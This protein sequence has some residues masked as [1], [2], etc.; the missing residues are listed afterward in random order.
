MLADL[1][2]N[3]RKRKK[4]K[5]SFSQNRDSHIFCF[6]W[7]LDFRSPSRMRLPCLV[8]LIYVLCQW[9]LLAIRAIT[10]SVIF[11]LI[12]IRQNFLGQKYIS[13]S[14]DFQGADLHK[15][16]STKG[17][18]LCHTFKYFVTCHKNIMLWALTF[19]IFLS[20]WEICKKSKFTTVYIFFKLFIENLLF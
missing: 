11:I 3:T 18:N 9:L 6:C 10:Y 5:Y 15:I 2:G 17:L 13:N 1:H 12:L 19:Y 14:Y 20:Y 8:W 7:N 4:K 16:P